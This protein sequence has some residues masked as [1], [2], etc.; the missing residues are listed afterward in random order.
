[1]SKESGTDNN[2][3]ETTIFIGNLPFQVNEEELR[4]H[5]C[6]VAGR[7]NTNGEG[8]KNDGIL[9]VRI[10]RDKETFLS[11][12]IAYIQYTSKPLMRMAI[13]EKNDSEFKGRKLR[14]KKAVDPKRLEKKQKKREEMVQMRKDKRQAARAE[15][16][17]S[18]S[19]NE[20][21]LLKEM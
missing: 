14:V 18:E 3:Y 17:G 5:F 2:D 9:N 4:R 15:Q 13:E 11:K 8:L 1:V 12:G 21:T 10:I 19:E 7:Q 16:S 20:E 6:D